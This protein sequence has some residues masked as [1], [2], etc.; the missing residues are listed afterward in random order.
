MYYKDLFDGDLE[1]SK[2]LERLDAIFDSLGDQQI[3]HVDYKIGPR[4]DDLAVYE[5]NI[6]YGEMNDPTHWITIT[7]DFLSNFVTIGDRQFWIDDPYG[8]QIAA[9][10]AYYHTW[11][12]KSAV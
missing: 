6:S 10:K 1:G 12:N 5:V 8:M 11:E 7:V 9:K 4:F 3:A 2:K